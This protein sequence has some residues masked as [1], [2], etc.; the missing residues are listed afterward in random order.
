MCAWKK[1]GACRFARVATRG[2]YVRV[3]EGLTNSKGEIPVDMKQVR[4]S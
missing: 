2:I 1:G 3:E 4:I